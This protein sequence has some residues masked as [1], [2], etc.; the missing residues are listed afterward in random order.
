MKWWRAGRSVSLD[1][2]AASDN[3]FPAMAK[4]LLFGI[5]L[6]W[7]WFGR[8]Q[9]IGDAILSVELPELRFAAGSFAS[10]HFLQPR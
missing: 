2:A 6:K 10:F 8:W 4:F 5:M 1:D 3:V 7:S 9:A